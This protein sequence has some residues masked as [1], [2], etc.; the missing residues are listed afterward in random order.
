MHSTLHLRRHSSG[1]NFLII[2]R[3]TFDLEMI[4]LGTENLQ[5]Q[6]KN[7]LKQLLRS[8]LDFSHRSG[9]STQGAPVL[10]IFL[11]RSEILSHAA[12]VE[13]FLNLVH[14]GSG[15]FNGFSACFD[16]RCDQLM[17]CRS[18]PL[19]EEFQK[20]HL[21]KCINLQDN[22]IRYPQMPM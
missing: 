20:L 8:R 9:L 5:D 1:N 22:T 13:K 10:P 6:S 18:Q 11:H 12:R 16:F 21:S 15:C 14:A 19:T 3:A 17:H 2:R 4:V 7:R